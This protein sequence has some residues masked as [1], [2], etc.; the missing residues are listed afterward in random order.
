MAQDGCRQGIAR[1]KARF[2]QVVEDIVE[3]WQ[4]NAYFSGNI[5]PGSL[6]AI[7]IGTGS[8][9]TAATTKTILQFDELAELGYTFGRFCGFAV[10]IVRQHREDSMCRCI[11]L[12]VD[13]GIIKWF[14]AISNFKEARR[15]HKRSRAKP[16]YL[17]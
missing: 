15:L 4:T 11:A 7:T 6:F 10:V 3:R 9:V 5:H 2:L 17:V 8:A 1:V 12:R 14:K 16:G 13:E